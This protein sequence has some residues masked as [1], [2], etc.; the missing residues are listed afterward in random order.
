VQKRVW[1]DKMYLYP[2]PQ[3]EIFINQSL[4]QNTGW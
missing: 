4:T 1:D 3:N 2:I